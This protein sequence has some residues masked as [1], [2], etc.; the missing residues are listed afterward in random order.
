RFSILL[1]LSLTFSQQAFC[2]EAT[3]APATSAP[4][5]GGNFFSK[6][7]NGVFSTPFNDPYEDRPY[8]SEA[9]KVNYCKVRQAQIES[10]K[11]ALEKLEAQLKEQQKANL[12]TDIAKIAEC[13]KETDALLNS[14]ADI[15]LVMKAA[16][17]TCDTPTCTNTCEMSQRIE[18]MISFRRHLLMK[19][20][21]TFHNE[22]CRAALRIDERSNPP[23]HG[24][25]HDNGSL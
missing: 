9:E 11:T 14:D 1:L 22:G 20:E 8:Q 13:E 21:S 19:L 18:R 16:A 7:S 3:S 4:E 10:N 17:G 2:V 5:A 12:A 15:E 25:D 24:D 6:P 23:S